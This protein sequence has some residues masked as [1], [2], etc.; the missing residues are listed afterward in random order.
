M[1]AVHEP[2]SSMNPSPVFDKL[3]SSSFKNFFARLKARGNG[4]SLGPEFKGGTVRVKPAVVGRLR[5]SD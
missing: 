1:R 2:I 5:I 3:C 4:T